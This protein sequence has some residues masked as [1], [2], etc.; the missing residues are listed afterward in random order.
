M[1]FFFIKGLGFVWLQFCVL[2]ICINSTCFKIYFECALNC[3]ASR[4]I[5]RKNKSSDENTGKFVDELCFTK[6]NIVLSTGSSSSLFF[7]ACRDFVEGRG[8]G[9][10]DTAD[11]DGVDCLDD[12]CTSNYC[13]SSYGSSISSF[14]SGNDAFLRPLVNRSCFRWIVCDRSK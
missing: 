4:L 11:G 3:C 8:G 2:S 5:E 13:I 6:F 10:F 12:A 14:S 9:A 7:F 1:F